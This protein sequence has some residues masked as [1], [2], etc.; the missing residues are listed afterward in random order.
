MATVDTGRDF[1]TT[2]LEIANRARPARRAEMDTSFYFNSAG[3]QLYG[4]YYP[5]RGQP[6][7]TGVVVCN[8]FGKEFEIARTALSVTCRDLAERGYSCLRFDYGGYGDSAADF[9]EATVTSM[10]ADIEAALGELWRRSS[11]RRLGLVGIRLGG[12]LAALVAARRPE[13]TRLVLWEPLVRPWET[14]LGALRHNVTMQTVIFGKVMF[15]REQIV[16]NVLAGRPSLAGGYNFNIIDEGFPLATAFVREIQK[17]DLVARAPEISA[18][19]LV[20]NI[21]KAAAPMSDDLARLGVALTQAHVPSDHASVVV[22]C[23][24]WMHEKVF[25]RRFPALVDITSRWCEQ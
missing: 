19:T 20:V 5:P 14:L 16:E 11:V 1:E 18:R 8:G 23:L 7:G 6:N 13:V 15:N 22:P 2:N 12:T 25:A 9:E 10:C 17:I 21:T 24:P 4:L 3:R